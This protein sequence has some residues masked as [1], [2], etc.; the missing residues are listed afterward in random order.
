MSFHKL[1]TACDWLSLFM[2]ERKKLV[3]QCALSHG[4]PRFIHFHYTPNCT[5]NIPSD[6]LSMRRIWISK[7][8]ERRKLYNN[9]PT[10]LRLREA[11]RIMRKLNLEK[12]SHAIFA[13][14]SRLRRKIL[15]LT[16]GSSE[17]SSRRIENASDEDQ[18]NGNSNREAIRVGTLG[19][20]SSA[21]FYF[22]GVTFLRFR[23]H[24]TSPIFKYQHTLFVESQNL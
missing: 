10:F 6:D 4:E 20:W 5:R 7:Q 17:F 2:S 11:L 1:P 8:S 24:L 16:R 23:L 12:F 13:T 18:R 14:F 15:T 21:E 19:T 9:S 3:T 22:V